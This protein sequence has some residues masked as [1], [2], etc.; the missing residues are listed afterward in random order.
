MFTSVVIAGVDGLGGWH[1][2][3]CS[4]PSVMPFFHSVRTRAT[5][6]TTP[7]F[8]TLTARTVYPPISAPAWASILTGMTPDQTGI[9]DN[10][11]P[12][13]NPSVFT[14]AGHV[15][16]RL[17]SSR[18]P[19]LEDLSP[20]AAQHPCNFAGTH[21]TTCLHLAVANSPPE[22]WCAMFSCWPWVPRLMPS[23]VLHPQKFQAYTVL[24]LDPLVV[25]RFVSMT[26]TV[27]TYPRVTFLHLNDIDTAGHN[28]HWGT[29]QYYKAM[30]QAD[31]RLRAIGQA[32]NARVMAHPEERIL[33]II[34]SD[35]GGSGEN[36]WR[37]L[38]SHMEVPIALVEYAAPH[39]ERRRGF[40]V[41]PLTTVLDIAPTVCA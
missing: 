12:N 10:D 38:P 7:L 40:D 28:Y 31:T 19:P 15:L 17:G 30:T 23:D 35:H 41:R 5:E 8:S 36:H 22:A 24:H 33:L 3:R 14:K 1:L 16:R 4:E 6:T 18:I 25:K 9:V 11:W 37:M 34:V 32:L 2:Q 29:P 20:P 13:L 21:P 39:K 27:G 26:E